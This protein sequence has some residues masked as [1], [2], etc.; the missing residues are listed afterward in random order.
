MIFESIIN[1]FLS[2]DLTHLMNNATQA[3]IK[4]I[5]RL[6][7]ED[8]TQG[9]PF[10]TSVRNAITPVFKRY[11]ALLGDFVFHVSQIVFF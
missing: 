11:S 1:H 3:Q 2:T 4:T 6:Y 10:N 7:P 5:L 8:I 9:S